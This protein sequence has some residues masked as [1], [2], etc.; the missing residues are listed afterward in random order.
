MLI[1]LSVAVGFGL[2]DIVDRPA[3][4]AQVGAANNSSRFQISS[5]SSTLGNNVIHGAYAIDTMTGVV[6]QVAAGQAPKRVA[7]NLP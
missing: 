7:E 5:Y 1:L 3:A 4:I 6:W 2:A